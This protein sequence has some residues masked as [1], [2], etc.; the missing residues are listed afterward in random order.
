MGEIKFTGECSAEP[1]GACRVRQI[2]TGSAWFDLLTGHLAGKSNLP[3]VSILLE[4]AM[5]EKNNLVDSLFDSPLHILEIEQISGDYRILIKCDGTITLEKIKEGGKPF[6]EQPM[7]PDEFW[8]A[9]AILIKSTAER[10]ASYQK[11]YQVSVECRVQLLRELRERKKFIPVG[12]SKKEM[13]AA[14][15]SFGKNLRK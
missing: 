10:L 8:K 5:P 4:R 13:F 14:G 2:L 6:A 9:L 11:L 3:Y 15:V 7:P 1:S 12:A